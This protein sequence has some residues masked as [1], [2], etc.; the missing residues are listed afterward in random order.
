MPDPDLAKT[1]ILDIVRLDRL[2]KELERRYRLNPTVQVSDL[3]GDLPAEER[4]PYAAQL[5]VAFADLKRHQEHLTVDGP[6][7]PKDADEDLGAS[8]QQSLMATA[9][10]EHE[11]A[12]DVSDATLQLPTVH[13]G[14]S[15]KPGSVRP[16]SGTSASGANDPSHASGSGSGTSGSSP[17]A[18][19]ER[20]EQFRI[21]RVLG[22]GAFGVVYL[23]EDEQL[24]RKVAIKMPKVSEAKR[25]ASYLNEAR[26]A[27]AIDCKG[28]VPIYHIGS[29]EAG[30]PF[31]V[32]KLIDGPSMRL[33][34]QRHKPYHRLTQQ[35]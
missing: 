24:Q 4:A 35:R 28:I 27:A 13:A 29:T 17:T 19:P 9:M 7:H 34:L 10:F 15:T 25:S 8:L 5:E 1:L 21:L 18:A 22:A 32:Q 16:G 31:V 12:G 2:T 20:I 11:L 14:G 26:K 6:S 30:V 33:L 23:A 3:L